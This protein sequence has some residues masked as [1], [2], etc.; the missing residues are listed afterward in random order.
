MIH[1]SQFTFWR[2]DT[3]SLLTVRHYSTLSSVPSAVVS[4]IKFFVVN[5]LEVGDHHCPL[6]IY[7]TYIIVTLY[8]SRCFYLF[9]SSPAVF[10][11]SY[12]AS[13]RSAAGEKYSR[14]KL[15]N[16][17][18]FVFVEDWLQSLQ[19]AFFFSMRVP[20]A[21]RT[22][23]FLQLPSFKSCFPKIT[24]FYGFNMS[25]SDIEVGAAALHILGVLRGICQTWNINTSRYDLEKR[26]SASV[27]YISNWFSYKPL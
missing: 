22:C 5:I 25:A 16:W 17:K 2:K 18:R 7:G 9:P 13:L 19:V 10:S 27:V 14:G 4:Q 24:R 23:R 1:C 15:I 11:C 6:Y 21:R 20:S 3:S 8:C 26:S 12:L